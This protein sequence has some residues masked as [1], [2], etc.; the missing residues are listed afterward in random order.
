MSLLDN[1]R[2][3]SSRGTTVEERLTALENYIAL[4]LGTA[5]IADGSITS[6]KIQDEAVS[7]LKIAAAAV[8]A[9]KTAIAA[10]SSSSGN[11]VGN[12]VSAYN[13]QSW[14]VTT[15]KIYAGA[16]TADKIT[17]SSLAAISA[18]IG[19]L[20]AGTL[21][22]LT[23]KTD[24]GTHP[25]VKID[26]S[27]I[28]CNGQ[29]ITLNYSSGTTGGVL[30]SDSSDGLVLS[31]VSNIPILL[32]GNNVT[33]NARSS[34]VD[35]NVASSLI[36]RVNSSGLTVY[37]NITTW[38]TIN[39]YSLSN[40]VT[41]S[42]FNS[43]TGSVSAHHSSTSNG[44]AITPSSVTA[45]GSGHFHGISCDGNIEPSSSNSRYC[46]TSGAYWARVYS[47]AYFTK[48][49]TLQT[50]WDKYDDLQVLR[51]LRTFEDENKLTGYSLDISSLPKEL[52]DKDFVDFGGMQS[53]GLCA[54]KKMVECIDDLKIQV[55]ILRE[56]LE[57]QKG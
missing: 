17:V 53:F 18:N 38:G 45:S 35:L 32:Q 39:G 5:D 6:D 14:A 54:M 27:G 15:D 21:V 36:C 23:I 44:I 20:T 47:D 1:P 57:K 50:G 33:I 22:G 41:S 30:Y 4:L 8:T 26:S 40:F 52:F 19:T 48:N 28:T 42:T 2:E 37:G 3:K 12:S 34:N 10:I 24:A 13:I 11:L 43:H 25:L 16:V 51:D 46:G 56:Q 7:E 49:T 9:A 31:A 55:D 29:G